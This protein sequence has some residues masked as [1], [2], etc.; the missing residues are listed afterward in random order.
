MISNKRKQTKNNI[1]RK[2]IK[3][4]TLLT[5]RV[6]DIVHKIM[7]TSQRKGDMI[8]ILRFIGGRSKQDKEFDGPPE[9]ISSDVNYTSLSV[10]NV[11]SGFNTDID[12]YS[13]S[14]LN[15]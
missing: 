4:T 8:I 15:A 9:L 13:R 6:K 1:V 14:R 5:E 2:F 10:D 12:F 7:R 11:W 3:T